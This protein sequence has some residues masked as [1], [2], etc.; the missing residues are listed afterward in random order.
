M[1]NLLKNVIAIIAQPSQA[2]IQV[3]S[4]VFINHSSPL[5]P[6]LGVERGGVDIPAA[7]QRD[8]ERRRHRIRGAVQGHGHLLRAVQ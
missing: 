2:S 1:A 8:V 4:S 3:F 6:G 7:A 5:E